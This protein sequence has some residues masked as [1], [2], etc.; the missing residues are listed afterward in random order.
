MLNIK[1]TAIKQ[2][3]FSR[4]H[5]ESVTCFWRSANPERLGC[6]L[7]PFAAFEYVA[8]MQQA[9]SKESGIY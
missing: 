1:Y 8:V 5:D 9:N 6:C 3:G 2:G 7:R 4:K